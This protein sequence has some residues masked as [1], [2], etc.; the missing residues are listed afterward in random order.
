MIREVTDK[1]SGAILFKKDPESLRYE[2]I[3]KKLKYQEKRI[4]KLEEI[5]AK[6]SKSNQK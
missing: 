3:Q 5:V 6:L 2:E 4:L 1:R